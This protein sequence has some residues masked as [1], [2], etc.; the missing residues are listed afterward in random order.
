MT[1][2]RDNQRSRLYSAEGISGRHLPTV[3]LMQSYVDEV[4]SSRWFVARW[5][6]RRIEVRDGRARRSACAVGNVIKM[7]TGMR[8]ESVVLHEVAH[9]LTPFKYAAH[10]PEF[11][12]VLLTL[13]GHEMG[14]DAHNALRAS[15]RAG[16]VKVSQKAIPSRRLPVPTQAQVAAKVSATRNRPNTAREATEAAEAIRR[17]VRVGVYGPAG[18][19]SRLAALATTRGLVS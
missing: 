12:G 2:P 7:P 5:G 4:L 9:V 19:K 10:G 11:A 1:R 13:V 6:K 15:F 14:P 17:A 18:S 16:G 8:H 3:T